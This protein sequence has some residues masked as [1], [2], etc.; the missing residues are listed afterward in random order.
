MTTIRLALAQINPKMGDLA[1]NIA[2][3]IRY[4]EQARTQGADII[5]LPE[6]AITGYPPEDL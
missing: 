1:G 6:L 2:K 3:I 5:A 4:I